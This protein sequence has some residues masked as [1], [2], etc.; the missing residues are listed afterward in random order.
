MVC[1]LHSTQDKLD[2]LER[3]FQGGNDKDKKKLSGKVEPSL[4][5]D[6]A[7]QRMEKLLERF[8]ADKTVRS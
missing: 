1:R 6:M 8:A 2:A 5:I 3:K 4:I 7:E